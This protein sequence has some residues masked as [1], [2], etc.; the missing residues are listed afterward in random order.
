MV[1]SCADLVVSEYFARI[2]YQIPGRGGF[3]ADLSC[4][5]QSIAEL[6]AV[7]QSFLVY[8]TLMPS[9][10]FSAAT[11]GLCTGLLSAGCI[12][13]QG[14]EMTVREATATV[15]PT[16]WSVATDNPPCE[17]QVYLGRVNT[18]REAA[19]CVRLCVDKSGLRSGQVASLEVYSREEKSGAWE[20]GAMPWAA[21]V[22]LDRQRGCAVFKNW[23]NNRFR[24]AR[25]VV[26]FK[27]DQ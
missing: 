22:D 26:G 14:G 4:D 12:F 17:I 23:S 18:T 21:W 15:A 9:E 1:P 25:I 6:P 24:E 16:Q 5:H 13:A 27:A 8:T 19:S 20:K 2:I 7:V 11:L 10:L 3:F